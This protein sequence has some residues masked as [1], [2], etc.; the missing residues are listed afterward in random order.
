MEKREKAAIYTRISRDKTGRGLALERQEEDCRLTCSLHGWEIYH[1]YSDDS[2]SA[3]SGKVR[4][5]YD[6]MISDFKAGKFDVIVA[7]KVDRLTRSVRG[8]EEMLDELSGQGLRICTNDMSDQDLSNADIRFLAQLTV[9][10]AQMESQRKS[11][12]EKRA[13]LQRAQRGSIKPGTRSFGYDRNFNVIPEEARLIRAIFSQYLKGSSMNAISRAIAGESGLLPDMPRSETPSIVFAREQ[14][15][16]PRNK[17]LKWSLATTQA[18][19][20]NP[21]YAGYVAYVPTT[22]GKCQ[23]PTSHWTDFIVRDEKGEPVKAVWEPIVE[24]DIWWAVQEKRD[25]NRYRKDG[26]TISRDGSARKHFGAGV[27]RCGVCGG[28][29]HSGDRSYRCDGHVNRTRNKVDRY[30]LEVIRQRLA[31]ADLKDL[32]VKTDEPRLKEIEQELAVQRGHLAQT[33]H[34]YMDN[35]IDGRLHKQKADKLQAEIAKLEGER[36]RLLPQNPAVDIITAEDPVKAFDAI[37]DPGQIAAII[38]YLAKVTLLPARQGIKQTP[39]TLREN[40]IIEWK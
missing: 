23:S 13:N 10:M 21:K 14:G 7:W 24:P 30:V 16:E 11:E 31:L 27:Y 29:M 19:L 35:L 26:S 6:K 2:I 38:N 15:K 40:V 1:V 36:L 4:P 3:F 33:D 37:T 9:G 17:E 28:P 32:L 25:R 18:I 39:E 20:R 34:D 22:G 5:Q 12:R 8:F